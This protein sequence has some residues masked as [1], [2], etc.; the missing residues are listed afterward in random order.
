MQQSLSVDIVVYSL[1][2]WM[3]FTLQTVAPVTEDL[4][5]TKDFP[6]NALVFEFRGSDALQVSK[7]AKWVW[8]LRL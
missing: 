6:T 7:V 4:F 1:F 5:E 3:H 8:G 2:I